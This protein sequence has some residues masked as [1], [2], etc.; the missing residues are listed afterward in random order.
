MGY[1][2][3]N[4]LSD[5]EIIAS[6]NSQKNNIYFRKIKISKN[7]KL[8]KPTTQITYIHKKHALFIDFVIVFLFAEIILLAAEVYT[9]V[10]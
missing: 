1:V 2:N 3:K 6:L 7:K 5:F 8:Y 4:I 10:L 9:C